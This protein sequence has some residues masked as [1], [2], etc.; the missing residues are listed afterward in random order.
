MCLY[1]YGRS[2]HHTVFDA[3]HGVV[4]DDQVQAGAALGVGQLRAVLGVI[5]AVKLR[6][7][8]QIVADVQ[9]FF[10]GSIGICQVDGVGG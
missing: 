9:A 2:N 7:P 1:V 6:D 4:V 8:G 3:D 5:R 10:G